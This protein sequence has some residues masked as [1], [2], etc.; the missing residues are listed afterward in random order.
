M[1]VALYTKYLRFLL[2]RQMVSEIGNI[3]AKQGLLDRRTADSCWLQ[4][5]QRALAVEL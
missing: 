4:Q 3:E 2:P 1:E 5:A